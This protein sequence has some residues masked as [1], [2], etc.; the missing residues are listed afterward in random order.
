MCAPSQSCSPIRIPELAPD[1]QRR[2]VAAVPAGKARGILECAALVCHHG[3]EQ[4]KDM[5]PA[6]DAA[7]QVCREL[8][9][10]PL[11]L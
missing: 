3:A 11:F 6:P 4:F 7:V 1:R 2:N 9:D 10:E 5:P 8:W